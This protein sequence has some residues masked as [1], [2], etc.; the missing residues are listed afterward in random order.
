[1][2]S[3]GIVSD[4]SA[5]TASTTLDSLASFCTA[6]ADNAAL[7]KTANEFGSQINSTTDLSTIRSAFIDAARAQAATAQSTITAT[8]KLHQYS[9]KQS[10]W[11]QSS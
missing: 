5:N 7:A 10:T 3:R 1:M 4:A 11:P 8:G 6:A 9:L 2:K